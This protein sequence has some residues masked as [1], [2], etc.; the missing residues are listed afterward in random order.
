MEIQSALADIP[1]KLEEIKTFEEIH[2]PSPNLHQSANDVFIAIFAVLERIINKISKTT[3]G[4]LVQASIAYL[5]NHTESVASKLKGTD[6]GIPEALEQL[7]ARVQ[8][9]KVQVD[10]CRDRR[11]GRTSETMEKV[12]TT[13]AGVTKLLNSKLTF[14]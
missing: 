8:Q 13:M 1:R 6:S 2:M 14:R 7:D 5:T 11:M 9:F 12:H 4:K 3:L 10:I